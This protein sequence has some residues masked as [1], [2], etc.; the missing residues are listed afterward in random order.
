[1]NINNQNYNPQFGALH[2]A[3][4]GKLKILKLTDRADLNF[5]KEL[6]E[7]VDI[8]RLMPNL[9]KDEYAR[10]NEMLEYAVDN[11]QKKENTTYLQILEGKPC[12]IITFTPGNTTKLD[13]ICTWPI[14]FGEKVKLAG[15]TL[16]YQMFKDFQQL[17][18]K[19]I[20]LDA[21]TNG[22]YDVVTKYETLGFKRT[23]NIHPTKVEMEI[24]AAK[25][26]ETIRTLDNLI[27]YENIKPEKIDLRLNLDI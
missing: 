4:S 9:T 7:R 26:K 15:K 1:M 3:N 21:I 25:I 8:Q 14:R 5:I 19:K 22:P 6:P 17:K 11:A 24:N 20:K 23:S 18:S 27:D 2:I 16:F 12:G 13:C 10:W